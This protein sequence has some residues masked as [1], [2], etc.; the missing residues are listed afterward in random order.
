[1]FI[2]ISSKYWSQGIVRV[3]FG[4]LMLLGWLLHDDYGVSTDEPAHYQHGAVNVK[5]VAD[6]LVPDLARQ[7]TNYKHIPTL[8]GYPDNGHGVLFEIPASLLGMFVAHGDSAIYYR[9]RHILIYLTFVVGVW[10]LYRLACLRFQDWRWGLVAAGA[11]VLSPRLFA[12]AFYNGQD[13]V[14]MSCFAVSMLTLVR[15]TQQPTISRAVVHGVCCA[16]ALDIR[17]VGVLLVAF[18]VSWIGWLILLSSE[19]RYAQR[20]LLQCLGLYLVTTAIVMVVCWPFLWEDPVGH[21]VEAFQ[22]MSRFPWLGR[23]LYL[24]ELRQG[25]QTPWHYVPVWISITTPW[26]YLVAAL[27]GLVVWML[28]I[29]RSLH[30]AHVWVWQFDTVVVAWFIVPLLSII[31][32]HSAVYNGW[33]HLYF[34]YPALLLLGVSG[35]HRIRHWATHHLR[36]HLVW[37]GIVGVMMTG[38][39]QTAY[40]MVKEHPYQQVYFSVVPTAVI[41]QHFDRDYWGLSYRSGLEW[42][43]ATD[44]TA[45]IPVGS[46]RIDLLYNNTLILP[47]AQRQRILLVRPPYPSGTYVFTNYAR[48][49]L[50]PSDTIG[51]KVYD[52]RV[53]GLPTLGIF[54][55]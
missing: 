5:Y 20:H 17:I 7:H 18:T 8:S 30:Q 24:G 48:F 22:Q 29:K 23:N 41:S 52:L 27:S 32:L 35:I 47:A 15:L 43:L 40:R 38:V 25:S 53:H 12:E 33:R 26:P 14:L 44:S 6:L 54:H 55:H 2:N 46:P 10:A 50:L 51:H 45:H 11:L 19:H 37:H 49:G 31:L 42:L 9:L 21:L 3:F 4:S 39:I 28:G 1:M 13:I 34:I 16:F 36:G